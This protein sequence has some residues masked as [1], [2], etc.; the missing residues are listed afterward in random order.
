MPK[1][2]FIT[3]TD[4]GVGKT[5]VAAALIRALRRSGISVGAMKPIETGCARDGDWLVPGDG[6]FLKSVAYMEENIGCVTPCKFESPLAPLA[7][8]EVEGVDIDIG[9]I[10]RQFAELLLKYD[11]VVVEGIGG[12]FVPIKRD[13]FVSDLAVDFGLPLI[14]VASPF[15]GTINHTLL[16]VDYALRK[17]LRVAGII[18]NFYRSP[19][20]TLAE[21]TNPRSIR[22]LSPAP[23]LGVLPYIKD[24]SVD[25]IDRTFVKHVD[26]EGVGQWQYRG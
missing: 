18:I 13:Y 11:A 23:L 17:G 15:L 12:L 3:G 1:G 9:E 14:V 19:D 7:A 10:K 26:I 8:S 16:T 21:Y 20:G 2:F 5:V 4:T 6:M 24:L 25:E 22:E